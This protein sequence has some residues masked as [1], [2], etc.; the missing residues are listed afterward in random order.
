MTV[1]CDDDDGDIHKFSGIKNIYD[2]FRN[3]KKSL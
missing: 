3:E 1:G 2:E